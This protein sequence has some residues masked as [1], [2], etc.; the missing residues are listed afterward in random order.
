[1]ESLLTSMET[2]RDALINAVAQ[3]HFTLTPEEMQAAATDLNAVMPK[4]AARVYYMASVNAIK[5]IQRALGNLPQM[6]DQYHRVRTGNEE[7]IGRFYK[8]WPGLDKAKHGEMVLSTAKAYRQANPNMTE[9]QFFRT[10]GQVVAAHFGLP[11]TSGGAATP[12]PAAGAPPGSTVVATAP[13]PQAFVPVSPGA[14]PV[15]VPQTGTKP[16]SGFEGLGLDFD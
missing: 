14:T 16:M 9:D 6:I 8:M 15:Q 5:Q 1:M 3:E 4:I 12:A 11:L 10:V 7:A 2:N 13:V